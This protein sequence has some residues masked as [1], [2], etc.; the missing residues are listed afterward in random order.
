MNEVCSDGTNGCCS[1]GPNCPSGEYWNG[2]TCAPYNACA[3]GESFFC[4]TGTCSADYCSTSIADSGIG[5]VCCPDG[6]VLVADSGS[7]TGWSC[8]AAGGT[9][10]WSTTGSNVYYNTGNVGIGTAN[11]DHT[12][13]LQGG[14][15]VGSDAQCTNA[16]TTAVG[17]IAW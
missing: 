8:A 15:C 6:E 5:K 2:L 11:I 1:L 9:G 4:G 7:S 10:N 12:L 13:D 3:K 16:V 17:D 14:V